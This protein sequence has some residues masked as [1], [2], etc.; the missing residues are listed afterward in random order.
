MSKQAAEDGEPV[1]AEVGE[2]RAG[3]DAGDGGER[4]HGQVG[5]ALGRG[6]DVCWD[7]A[8]EQG[9]A[10]DQAGGPA[11]AQQDQGGSGQAMR[12]VGSQCGTVIAMARMARPMPMVGMRP[13]RS[14]SQPITG[15]RAY[16]PAT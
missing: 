13:R 10:R 3:G 6:A 11:E 7:R 2:D 16:M 4:A 15:D 9:G 8:G 14:A 12:V 5:Q 1:E